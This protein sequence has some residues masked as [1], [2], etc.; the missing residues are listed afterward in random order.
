MIERIRTLANDHVDPI[1][2]RE[3][4]SLMRERDTVLQ[5]SVLST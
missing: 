3:T 2:D 4:D 5:S 1:G